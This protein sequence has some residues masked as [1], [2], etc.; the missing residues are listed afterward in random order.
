M[1]ILFGSNFSFCLTSGFFGG[2]DYYC[3]F[4]HSV[5]RDCLV[6]LSVIAH[7]CRWRH[8]VAG[9]FPTPSRRCALH[10]LLARISSTIGNPALHSSTQSQAQARCN[11]TFSPP[12]DAVQSCIQVSQFA[13]GHYCPSGRRIML[14]WK[15][16]NILFFIKSLSEGSGRDQRE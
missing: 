11:N 16:I 13:Q 15:L 2:Y 12:A 9:G 8:L 1:P 14:P 7:S 10:L 4:R 5:G 3:N 6:Q